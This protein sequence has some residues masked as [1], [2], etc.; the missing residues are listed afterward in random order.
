MSRQFEPK[1]EVLQQQQQRL[2]PEF[3]SIPQAFR[4]CGGTAIALHLGHRASFDFDFLSVDP[5]DPDWLYNELP[6]LQG[7][8]VLQKAA[9]TLTTLVDRDEPVQLSFF[10]V[11]QIQFTDPPL[12][13]RDNELRVASMRD[14]AAMKAAVVQKRAEAKDYIDIDA[15]LCSGQINLPMA[16]AAARQMYGHGFNPELTLKS[17]CYFGDGNLGSVPREIQDRLAAAVAA[18]NTNQLPDIKLQ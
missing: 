13:C 2:W 17:L 16:L 5:F 9:N 1:L 18:V 12:V 6:F 10:G 3:A 11:P 4:L 15:I 7:S 14:L 8:G